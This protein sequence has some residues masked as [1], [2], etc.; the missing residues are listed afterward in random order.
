[1][2]IFFGILFFVI[3]NRSQPLKTPQVQTIESAAFQNVVFVQDFEASSVYIYLVFPFGEANNP[4]DE[5]LAHYVEHLA[6]ISTFGRDEAKKHRHSNAWTTHLSTGYWQVID[7]HDLE[8]ALQGLL[9]LSEPLSVDPKFALEERNIIQREY[10]Y[11]VAERPIYN[12]LLD[13]RRALYG[14]GTLAKS[15]I[16]DPDEI[17]QYDLDQAMTLHQKTHV[18]SD[19]TLLIYGNT[20]KL[21]LENVLHRLKATDTYSERPDQN[22][23]VESGPS[24][25]EQE[26]KIPNIDEDIFMYS[27]VLPLDKSSDTL[28]QKLLIKFAE[29]VIDSTRPEGI[30]GPLCFDQFIARHFTFDLENIGNEFVKLSFTASPDDAATLD[31]VETA[32]HQALSRTLT[33]GI[34]T[35]TFD[36][37]YARR[38]SRYTSI[39]ARERARF[40]RDLILDQLTGAETIHTLS[41]HENA[42]KDITLTDVNVFLAFLSSEGREVTRKILRAE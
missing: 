11:R 25:D 40:N 23:W 39:L 17:A 32:F 22:H 31:D 16:G 9:K 6:W 21:R 33:H 1:M 27:K 28:R 5:G 30:A 36:R 15:V 18:L 4:F 10:D 7:A 37:I 34:S 2:L 14:N 29:N 42:L 35:E 13:M 8:S 26:L 3:L 24:V 38:S 19:A 41:E 12:A 20:S